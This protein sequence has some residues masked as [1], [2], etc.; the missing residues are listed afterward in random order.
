MILTAFLRDAPIR[1]KLLWIGMLTS[2]VAVVSISLILS[3][4]ITME[5]Y[6]DAASDV[7]TYTR[8]VGLNAASAVA[9]DDRKAAIC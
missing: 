6:D 8:V 9:F 7:M 3:I 2:G 5:R 4:R 1:R